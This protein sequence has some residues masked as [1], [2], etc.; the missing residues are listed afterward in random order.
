M[1][2]PP[3]QDGPFCGQNLPQMILPVDSLLAGQQV[4]DQGPSSV[5]FVSQ[6]NKWDQGWFPTA[7]A[8]LTLYLIRCLQLGVELT[9]D[10]LQLLPDDIG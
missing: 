1:D 2:N 8:M 10:L 3:P 7:G 9:E 4:P 5:V 6:G